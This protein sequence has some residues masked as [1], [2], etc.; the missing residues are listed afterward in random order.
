[1]LVNNNNKSILDEYTDYLK[2]K[3]R[4]TKI[5]D[6]SKNI[7]IKLSS[8]ILFYF[9]TIVSIAFVILT[10]YLI[11]S[12]IIN[13]NPYDDGNTIIVVGTALLAI[14][15]IGVAFNEKKNMSINI[16]YP[17]EKQISFNN[18]IFNIETED[19]YIDITKKYEYNSGLE[20]KSGGT[21][22]PRS[23]MAKYFLNIKGNRN[24]KSIEIKY[25]IEE[26][27][28]DFIYNFEYEISDLKM[29]KSEILQNMQNQVEKMY[30]SE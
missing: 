1:M 20:T 8:G 7:K 25:G 30:K 26:Q 9:L 2:D 14:I 12:T 19:C 18:K 16:K 17:N 24:S 3:G 5:K 6:T 13:P 10:I 29:K 21:I 11:G 4:I 28:Q 23:H 27:L 15:V 22:T